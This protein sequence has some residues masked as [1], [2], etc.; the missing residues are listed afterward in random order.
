MLNRRRLISG[1]TYGAGLAK[2]FMVKLI[3]DYHAGIVEQAIIL[4]NN[5]TDTA[6]F[7]ETLGMHASAFCFPS[8]RIQFE[9]PPNTTRSSNSRGQVLS[10]IGLD[11]TRF[12]TEFAQFGL[13][14]LPEGNK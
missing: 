12:M 8:P 3:T 13:I 10:Y 4:T 2:P 9:K 6:W 14:T 1:L 5:V 11:H 7:T